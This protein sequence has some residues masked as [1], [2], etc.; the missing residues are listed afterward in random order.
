MTGTQVT[1]SQGTMDMPAG[2]K[3]KVILGETVRSYC[4]YCGKPIEWTRDEYDRRVA[5]DP[6][7]ILFR[8]KKENEKGITVMDSLGHIMS[9]I[10]INHPRWAYDYGQ[11]LHYCFVT[12]R[13]GR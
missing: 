8:E 11:R 12:G 9:G 5:V 7:I 2:H 6:K 1:V 10:T 3:T 13:L 4:S